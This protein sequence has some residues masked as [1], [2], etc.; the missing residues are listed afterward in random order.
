MKTT[1]EMLSTNKD[2]IRVLAVYGGDDRRNQLRILKSGVDVIV[3]TPGRLID[4]IESNEIK[5]D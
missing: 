4:F 2:L 3:A 1:F 5:F